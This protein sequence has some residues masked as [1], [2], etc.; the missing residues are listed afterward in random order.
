MPGRGVFDPADLRRR[1]AGLRPRVRLGAVALRPRRAIRHR[2]ALEA[3]VADPGRSRW[4]R[5]AAP[6]LRG[7]APRLVAR[8]G[9]SLPPFATAPARVRVLR[10]PGGPPRGL[11]GILVGSL[12]ARGAGGRA[13]RRPAILPSASARSGGAIDRAVLARDA[14]LRAG[15]G[16]RA[17]RPRRGVP[18]GPARGAFFRGRR[19][20]LTPRVPASTNRPGRVGNLLVVVRPRPPKRDGH[21]EAIRRAR[22]LEKV[23]DVE[24]DR[25]L[26]HPEAS[27]HLAIGQPLENEQIMDLLLLRGQRPRVRLYGGHCRSG[28]AIAPPGRG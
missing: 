19:L 27:G 3:P 9:R 26:G 2:W 23:L 1:S 24:L 15:F 22:L 28:T 21:L 20:G 4:A 11:R 5:S 8:R 6:R 13:L 17:G 10:P 25:A 12:R 18:F 14:L 16:A 7:S